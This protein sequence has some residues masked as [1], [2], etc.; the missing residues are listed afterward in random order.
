MY[1][2]IKNYIARGCIWGLAASMVLISGEWIAR[3]VCVQASARDPDRGEIFAPGKTVVYRLEG[4]GR[5]RWWEGGIR[6]STAPLDQG[7]QNVLIL[8]DSFTEALQVSDAEVYSELLERSLNGDGGRWQVI[9]AGTS[10][11]SM[12]DYV[13]YPERLI[14][15]W[16]PIW[17]IVQV[18]EPDFKE[19]AW[20]PTKQKRVAFFRLDL[21]K[22]LN[23][24]SPD[25]SPKHNGGLLRVL[26]RT[27]REHS[28]LAQFSARRIEEFI[29]WVEHERPLFVGEVRARSQ[30]TP[31]RV[32]Y[33]IE[34]QVQMLKEK[35]GGRVTVLFLSPFDPR[36]RKTLTPFENQL[37]RL[38][39]QEGVSFASLSCYYSTQ[40]VPPHRSPFGFSNSGFN[41][42][43]MNPLGHRLAAEAVLQAVPFHSR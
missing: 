11:A 6:R 42:G 33:C 30:A 17:T 40:H 18:Q 19:D 4:N 27:L 16:N 41:Q 26:V 8:G 14:K 23:I 9:N 22:R 20:S 32:D 10:G 37:R 7:P 36:D 31:L 1:R 35:F 25:F 5:S 24:V 28:A 13:S 38:C 34:E 15:R 29:A 43:H 3:Q 2:V 12:A 21:E 39:E